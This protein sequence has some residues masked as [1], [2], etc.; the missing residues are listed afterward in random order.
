MGWKDTVF[1]N[2][3][4][5]AVTDLRVETPDFLKKIEQAYQGGADIVQLRS[6]ALP[7]EVLIRLGLKIRRLAARFR[8][9]FFVND[10]VDLALVIG[11]DGVHLGQDD[12]PV[13]LARKLM[14]QAG[15]K[16]WIG[17]ST[18]HLQQAI[19]AQRERVDYIGVGPVFPTPTKP[20]AVPVGL[21]FVRQV[22]MTIRIPWVAIGGINGSNIQTVINAGARRVAVVRAVFAVKNTGKAAG[23]LKKILAP[24]ED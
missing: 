9:L 16:L 2:F 22:S 20:G 8:K 14:R 5:Y 4:L 13:D 10:R 23:Q 18:H 11:A 15:Q 1:H 17:K 3:R 19:A 21:K 6:K 24:S 12:M 7:D